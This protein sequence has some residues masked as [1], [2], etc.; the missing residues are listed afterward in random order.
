MDLLHGWCVLFR[1]GKKV[2][3]ARLPSPFVRPVN[4]SLA[5][6][7]APDWQRWG[8]AGWRPYRPQ[9]RAPPAVCRSWPPLRRWWWS[10]RRAGPG[11]HSWSHL[12]QHSRA[13]SDGT[14]VSHQD[15]YCTGV[16]C[17][18]YM[19]VPSVRV[20]W[21]IRFSFSFWIWSLFPLTQTHIVLYVH[22]LVCIYT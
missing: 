11:L 21:S 1:S 18:G 16:D 5:R 6:L 9:S 20:I 3:A 13:V 14:K 15:V 19:R 8:W 17:Y 2:A 12:E 22:P 10:R 4:R 7:Y